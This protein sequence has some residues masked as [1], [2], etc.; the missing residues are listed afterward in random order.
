MF[1]LNKRLIN[2]FYTCRR[3]FANVSRETRDQLEINHSLIFI[4]QGL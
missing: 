4:L 3:K 1:E 2:F